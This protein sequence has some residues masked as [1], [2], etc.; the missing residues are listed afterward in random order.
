MIYDVKKYKAIQSWNIP[1]TS[2]DI[3]ILYMTVSN[4][5][6]KIGVALGKHVIKE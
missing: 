3:E 6:R 4:D 1:N 5:E 2:S